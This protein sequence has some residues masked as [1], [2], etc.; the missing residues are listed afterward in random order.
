MSE[1]F[2]NPTPEMKE[3]LTRAGS[4]DPSEFRQYTPFIAKAIQEP[5]REGLLAGDIVS[6]IFPAQKFDPTQPV[7]FQLDFIAPGTQKDYTAWTLTNHGYIPEKTVEGDYVTI[8]MYYVGTSI[9]WLLRY[10][11]N[12]RWDIVGRAMRVMESM[13]QKKIND[14]GWHT[15]LAAASDRNIIVYDTDA[16]SGQFTKRIVSLMK[17]IMRR[18]GGG[19]SA[20]NNRSKLTDLYISPEAVE[21]MRNWGI[22]IIDEVTRRELFTAE[23][24]TFG[25]IFSVNLHDIDELGEQQ[26]YQN[27]FSNIIGGSLPTGKLELALGLDRN[28]NDSLVMPTRDGVQVF[29]DEALHRKMRAGYYAWCELGF[30]VLDNRRVILGGI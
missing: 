5:L 12:A 27:F 23:D 9:D 1:V 26:E 15:L 2:D 10:S 22:D 28:K 3:L 29:P 14:D 16:G 8:P 17:T 4:L 18:Q 6:D 19:N 13:F 7:E 21:D 25:R 11:R 20:T 30:A 24:G